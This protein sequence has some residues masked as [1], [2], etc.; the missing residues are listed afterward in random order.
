MIP[1][2]LNELNR[3]KAECRK[4][5]KKRAALSAAGAVVPVPGVDVGV[6]IA[7][8][9]ELLNS[10]NKKFGLSSEQVDQLD[11]ETKGR[12]LVILSSLATDVAGKVISRD[13]VIQLLKK[14]AGRK[15]V[16]QGGKYIPFVG[17]A[18][19]AG[20]SYAAM[21]YLGNSHIDECYEVCKHYNEEDGNATGAYAYR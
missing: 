20:I 5:V 1:K 12:L 14:I 8:M 18:M 11:A 21:V 4:M 17:Q 15:I 6:D 9:M 19:A 2:S 7:I 3:V 10:I 16:V 13:I